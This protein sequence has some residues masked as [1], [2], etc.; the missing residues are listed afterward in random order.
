M[1]IDHEIFSTVILS[2]PMFQEGQLLVS[3]KRMSTMLVNCLEDY[4]C[5]VKVWLGELT[6][7]DMIPLG[8]LGHKTSTQINKLKWCWKGCKTPSSSSSSSLSFYTDLPHCKSRSKPVL[9]FISLRKPGNKETESIIQNLICTWL[10]SENSNF[11][12]PC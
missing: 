7:L 6:V 5:P 10:C 11:V 2:L 3:G 12:L 4:T 1:E 8:W 9:L